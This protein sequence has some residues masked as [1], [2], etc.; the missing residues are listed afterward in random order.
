MRKRVF[1]LIV[2]L[3]ILVLFFA[4]RFLVINEEPKKVDVIVVLS[5]GEGR[6]EKGIELYNSGYARTIIVS[7]GLA[8]NLWENA[9]TLLPRKS[10]LL[11]DK[12]ESTYESAVYLKEIMESNNYHSAIVVSSDYHM[13]RVKYNFSRVYRGSHIKLVFI[14]SDTS[15]DPKAWWMSKHNFGVTM[16]EYIK[17]IGNTFGVYGN[18]AKRKL[19][20]Y[21][22]VFFE[23]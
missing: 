7:N 14:S 22:E 9:I 1:L 19:Y 2:F 20:Q 21:F 18:D 3:I 10:V 13:R 5:G 23:E 6:L 12:A 16:S 11:E 15:Y 8:D 4:G 17:I